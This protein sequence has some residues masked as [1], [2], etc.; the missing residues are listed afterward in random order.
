MNWQT[1]LSQ[2][3]IDAYFARMA[4]FCPSIMEVLH[5][6]RTRDEM[7]LRASERQAWYSHNRDG[8]VLARSFLAARGV[9]IEPGL[10]RPY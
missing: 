3:E 2:E 7:Q 1:I 10:S 9:K 6:Y 5:W 4:E 8:Y